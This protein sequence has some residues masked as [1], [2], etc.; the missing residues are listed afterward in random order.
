[1]R[2]DRLHRLR[3]RLGAARGT[4]ARVLRA[5]VGAPD[6]DAYL[7]HL[8]RHHPGATPLSPRAFAEQRWAD[9]YA[10]PGG[11]CC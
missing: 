10:R 3:R 1:M 5:V 11:R 6:Y 4:L 8:L 7:A 9:R 2:A